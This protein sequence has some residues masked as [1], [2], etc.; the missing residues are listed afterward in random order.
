MGVGVICGCLPAFRSLIGYIFAN[1]KMILAAGN[2]GNT[3]AYANRSRSIAK[4]DHKRI[5]SFNRMFMELDDLQGSEDELHNKNVDTGSIVS[6]SS[7]APITDRPVLTTG[8]G[9]GNRVRV[10]AGDV[11]SQ[12]QRINDSRNMIVMTKTVEQ[13]HHRS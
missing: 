13:S 6:H 12:Q 5:G 8:K 2:T 7:E 3:P 4:G 11:E 10:N 9:F 1:F